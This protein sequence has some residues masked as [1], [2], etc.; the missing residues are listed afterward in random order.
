MRCPRCGEEVKVHWT[1][2][3]ACQTA[4]LGRER[5]IAAQASGLER[6]VTD[7][8]DSV[9]GADAALAG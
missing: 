6:S 8:A 3:P 2:C 5:D 1:A 7:G 9:N 4:L